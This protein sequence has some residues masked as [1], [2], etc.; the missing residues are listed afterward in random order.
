MK[1]ENREF[2]VNRPLDYNIVSKV[3]LSTIGDDTSLEDLGI[4]ARENLLSC[5][6]FGQ[7][8]ARAFM[9]KFAIEVEA[10]MVDYGSF[11]IVRPEDI[12]RKSTT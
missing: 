3:L 10:T 12:L 8:D 2:V 6:L 7:Y 9:A 11:L 1:I 5:N 4:D